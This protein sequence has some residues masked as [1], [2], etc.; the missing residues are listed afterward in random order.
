M[1]EVLNELYTGA[2]LES[3]H[4]LHDGT[5]LKPYFPE[6][7]LKEAVNLAI[8]LGKPL[9]VMGEP[10]CGKTKLASSVAFEI[11]QKELTRKRKPIKFKDIFFEWSVKSTSKA[12]DGLYQYNYIKKLQDTQ[13]KQIYSQHKEDEKTKEEKEDPYVNLGPL[14][15]VF[16][17]SSQFNKP[18]VL[19]I[20]EIDKAPFDFPNDLLRELDEM[21]FEVTETKDIIKAD[22]ENKP[23]IVITSNDEKDLP[24]PFFEKVSFL[25]HKFPRG[26]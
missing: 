10:G 26:R 22:K 6:P 24:V 18:L 1:D 7:K 11:F 4:H 2:K 19:L 20:D 14:G 9:L 3:T 13:L 23:L 16:Q 8:A 17:K 25:S 15:T 5:Q 21:K 12:S